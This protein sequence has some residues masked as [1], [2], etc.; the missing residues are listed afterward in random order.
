MRGLI[1]VA[2]VLVLMAVAGAGMFGCSDKGRAALD[3]TKWTLAG[4][5]VSSLY[6]GDYEITAAFSDGSMSGKAAVN[7]YEG[8]YVAASEKRG[9]SSFSTGELAR[10]LM[11]GPEPAMRA[12]HVFLQLLAQA[13]T[14]SLADGILTLADANGNQLLI[15]DRAG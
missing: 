7:T 14:Y 11:A 2:G 6:P 1:R 12:E 3:G 8:T 4:W 15:F 9:G 13:R 5:S 10:T